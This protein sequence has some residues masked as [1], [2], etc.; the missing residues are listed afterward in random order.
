LKTDEQTRSSFVKFIK[1]IDNDVKLVKKDKND[2]AIQS[3]HFVKDSEKEA[4][5]RWINK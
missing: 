1:P 5:S 2:T 3:V 4:F